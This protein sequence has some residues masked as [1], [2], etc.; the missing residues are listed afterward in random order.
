V[1]SFKSAWKRV[2]DAAKVTARFHDG[3]HTF[4]TDLAETGASDEVI[5]STVGHVSTQMLRHYSHVR[6]EA[7]RAALAAMEERNTKRRAATQAAIREENS[8]S[9]STISST[10]DTIQ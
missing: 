10:L 3:R 7:K 4:I 9:S 8:E 2:K 5:R 6:T 1:T